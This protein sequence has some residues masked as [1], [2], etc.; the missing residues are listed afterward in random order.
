MLWS[1]CTNFIGT[2]RDT[3]ASNIPKAYVHFH[4][5]ADLDQR[6]SHLPNKLQNKMRQQKIY[7]LMPLVFAGDDGDNVAHP[8][9][10]PAPI[11]PPAPPPTPLGGNFP[12][13]E[14]RLPIEQVDPQVWEPFHPLLDFLQQNEELREPEEP[15]ADIFPVGPPPPTAHTV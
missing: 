15:P 6:S 8:P 9:T 7:E 11:V 1:T 10:P 4:I 3:V 2:L 13:K 12:A 14:F 5:K